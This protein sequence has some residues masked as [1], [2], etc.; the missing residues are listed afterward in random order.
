VFTPHV[1]G[2][3]GVTMTL[4]RDEAAMFKFAY[5]PRRQGESS[6]KPNVCPLPDSAKS[7]RWVRSRNATFACAM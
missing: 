5:R 1:R 3:D 6:R 7:G 2:E 4:W